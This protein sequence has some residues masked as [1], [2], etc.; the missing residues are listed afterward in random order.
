MSGD[1]QDDG[2]AGESAWDR[3]VREGVI[4]LGDP[5]GPDD[6]DPLAGLLGEN[7]TG[8]TAEELLNETR[9]DS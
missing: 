1:E 4:K 7:T 6:P 5:W 2:V 9:G 3:M 8:M